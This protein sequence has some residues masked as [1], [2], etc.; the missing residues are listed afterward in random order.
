MTTH[1]LLK[2]LY[3]VFDQAFG[4]TINA[5]AKPS[6]SESALYYSEIG[7][8][9]N[10]ETQKIIIGMPKEGLI[11]LNAIYF[12]FEEDFSSEELEDFL[13]ELSNMI[14][15][16]AKATFSS[17]KREI[18]LEIPQIMH[19]VDLDDYIKKYFIVKNSYVIM[20][21]KAN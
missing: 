7:I 4:I 2:S 12:G 8:T 5:L 9:E 14:M 20:A 15:G 13:K 1:H 10:G 19:S 18:K 17:E 21:Y 11:A 3:E 16:K 6:I